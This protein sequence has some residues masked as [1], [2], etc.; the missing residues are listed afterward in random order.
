MS[1]GQTI[2]IA[3]DDPHIRQV[4][5]FAVEKAGYLVVEAKDGA[6]ALEQVGQCC[7]DLVI[8]DVMMPE[9]D[10]TEVCRRLRA[11]SAVPV[12]FLS[13]RDEEIDRI[14]GLELGGDDYVTK[15]FSPRELVARIKAVLRRV[16]GRVAL[17]E[18]KEKEETDGKQE[19]EQQERRGRE[20]S[21]GCLALHLDEFR[22]FWAEE[23]IE[24]TRREFDLLRVLLGYP[25]KVF[26][27]DELM[28]RAYGTGVIVSDRTIDSHVRR[29]RQKFDLYDAQPVETVHGIG[30]RLGTCT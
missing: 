28:N 16:E 15:P 9:M 25:G 21:H 22:A 10:G 7:P 6:E 5:R 18:Q 20:I 12:L 3:D 27:R 30:Y 11:H 26:S 24:L 4:V 8:L 14:I 19:E 29:L 13:S 1:A 2:L 23:E 17:L